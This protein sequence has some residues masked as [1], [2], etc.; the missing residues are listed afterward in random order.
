[1]V[2]RCMK[3]LKSHALARARTSGKKT[4]GVQRAPSGHL[5]RR[6][7]ERAAAYVRMASRT[8]RAQKLGSARCTSRKS[9]RS[10][11]DRAEKVASQGS[12]VEH[13]MPMSRGLPLSSL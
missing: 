3:M 10:P 2:R 9:Q 1:M 8:P 5:D 6:R 11:R 7:C 12:G 4:S 13:K